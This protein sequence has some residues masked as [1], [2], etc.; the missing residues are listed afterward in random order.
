MGPSKEGLQTSL[1]GSSKAS[2][3]RPHPKG[4]GESIKVSQ[5]EKDILSGGYT[6]L[7]AHAS[8]TTFAF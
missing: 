5:V 2:W 3:N 4:L 8:Q 1:A 6:Q 7:M